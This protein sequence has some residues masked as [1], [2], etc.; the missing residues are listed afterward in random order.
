AARNNLANAY[1]AAGQHDDAI[2]LYERTLAD[3][4]RVNGPDHTFTVMVRDNLAATKH[5]GPSAGNP[6]R[7]TDNP[8]RP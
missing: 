5:R 8:D 2:R 1:Q 3:S 4:V 7:S 6:T